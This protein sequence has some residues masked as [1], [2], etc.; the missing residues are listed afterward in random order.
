MSGG[1]PVGGHRRW[2]AWCTLALA[3][4][5]AV[6]LVAVI[7]ALPAAPQ[8]EQTHSAD[9]PTPSLFDTEVAFWIHMSGG[10]RDRRA[11]GLT[12]GDDAF[13]AVSLEVWEALARGESG[14]SRFTRLES[15]E[16][17]H[18]ARVWVWT[19]EPVS[20]PPLVAYGVGKPSSVAALTA[21]GLAAGSVVDTAPAP[22]EPPG[23][24]EEAWTRALT[25]DGMDPAFN[26]GVFQYWWGRGWQDVSMFSIV[27]G[28]TAWGGLRTPGV[29][30]MG[31]DSYFC[32]DGLQGIDPRIHDYVGILDAVALRERADIWVMGPLTSDLGGYRQPEGADPSTGAALGEAVWPEVFVG[33]VGDAEPV[34]IELTPAQASLAGG[35]LAAM[36][37]VTYLES[38]TWSTKVMASGEPPPSALAFLV[39]YNEI[40]GRIEGSLADAWRGFVGR[41]AAVALAV[42][43]LAVLVLA[44]LSLVALIT[45]RRPAGR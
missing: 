11:A 25:Q 6:G 7:A 24:L 19:I 9:E 35:P 13:S 8:I 26:P 14:D 28:D 29:G 21:E 41:H 43:I 30:D 10:L 17:E 16:R 1:A 2:L 18:D 45:L 20:T 22:F 32:P 23:G 3:L 4:L 40:P 42:G 12:G 39:V 15:W 44:P 33:G 34:P 37:V 5:A 36:E 31:P 38:P 27:V